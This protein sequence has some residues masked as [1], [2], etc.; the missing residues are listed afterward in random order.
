MKQYENMMEGI[1]EEEM[2]SL[3]DSLGCCMC[4]Q[5]WSDIAAHALNHL[6][7]RYVVTRAGGAISKADSLQ[8]RKHDSDHGDGGIAPQLLAE[9]LAD[10]SG[11]G[12]GQQGD[13]LRPL[14][15]EQASHAAG[16]SR[17]VELGDIQGAA[18]SLAIVVT[19]LLTVATAPLFA[20]L[21]G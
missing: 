3:R 15:P 1:V 17:A 21:G 5:C 9:P 10:G 11:D 13:I 16:T 8:A 6:P 19:G 7:P 12:L 4:E 14:H 18:S 2:E 20:K